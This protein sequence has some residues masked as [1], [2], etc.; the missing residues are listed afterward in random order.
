MNICE[1]TLVIRHKD[2]IQVRP[3][4]PIVA[5]VAIFRGPQPRCLPESG[6]LDTPD[7]KAFTTLQRLD[8]SDYSNVVR[9]LIL[10]L[11]KESNGMN[12]SVLDPKQETLSSKPPSLSK[13]L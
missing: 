9:Y 11:V 3:G 13:C 1:I 8:S 10:G 5:C 6:N 12:L 4:G 7:L 2:L